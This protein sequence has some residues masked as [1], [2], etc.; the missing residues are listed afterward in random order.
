MTV[1]YSESKVLFQFVFIIDETDL[2]KAVSVPVYGAL[3]YP[4]HD[5]TSPVKFWTTNDVSEWMTTNSIQHL[6]D[7]LGFSLFMAR[8]LQF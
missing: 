3:N 2:V 4:S 1:Y 6:R 8:S 7:W 5:K